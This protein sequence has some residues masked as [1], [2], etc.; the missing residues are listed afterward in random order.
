MGG[1]EYSTNDNFQQGVLNFSDKEELEAELNKFESDTP[2][3]QKYQNARLALLPELA[4]TRSGAAC[5]IYYNLS[6][7]LE[8]P[9]LL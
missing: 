6:R 3:Q 5:I 9:G 4:H 1:D 8:C 7:S 2:G